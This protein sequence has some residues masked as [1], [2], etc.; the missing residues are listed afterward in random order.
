MTQT[1]E[2]FWEQHYSRLSKATNGKPSVVLT[3]FIEARAI[4]NALDLGCARGDDAIWM[5]RQGWQVLGVDISENALHAARQTVHSAGL[6]ERCR[7][8]RHTLG[9]TFPDGRYDLVTALFLHSP[10]D[11]D[12]T[13]VLKQ[14]A[15]ATAPGGLLLVAAHGSRAPWSWAAPDT[16]YRSAE[17]ELADL[18]LDNTIWRRVFVGPVERVARG[19]NGQS[20]TVIDT[21]I[22][23]ER[24]YKTS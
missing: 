18:N 5:A 6:A 8:E 15:E 9:E 19:P 13:K 3:R 23:L 12:R 21:V 7:F 17:E 22:A 24:R 4:G 2:S 14:A 1:A 11:F 10:V 16:T 20:A